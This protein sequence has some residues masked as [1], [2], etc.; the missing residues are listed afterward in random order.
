M[1]SVCGFRYVLLVVPIYECVLLGGKT[2]A[3]P[4]ANTFNDSGVRQDS[5]I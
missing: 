4:V 2:V 5:V 1:I 3:K